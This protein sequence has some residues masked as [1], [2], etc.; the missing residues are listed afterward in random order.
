MTNVRRAQLIEWNL[1]VIEQVLDV[2]RSAIASAMDWRALAE[3]VEEEKQRSNPLALRIAKLKLDVNQVTLWLA[4]PT[5]RL[6]PIP[7]VSLM[8]RR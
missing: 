6:F 2:V 8:H 1:D 7:Y 5:R 3:L 4:E